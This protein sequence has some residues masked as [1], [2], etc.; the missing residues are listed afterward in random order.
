M[1]RAVYM[2]DEKKKVK[3]KKIKEIGIKKKDIYETK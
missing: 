1:Q 2:A 3:H